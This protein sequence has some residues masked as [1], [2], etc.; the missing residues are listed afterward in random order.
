MP[1]IITFEFAV[2]LAKEADQVI[3]REATNSLPYHNLLLSSSSGMIGSSGWIETEIDWDDAANL[4]AR[5]RVRKPL[6]GLHQDSGWKS[7]ETPK[8]KCLAGLELL[9]NFINSKIKRHH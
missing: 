7:Y 8:Y 3:Y 1:A 4:G 2:E 5:W 9:T 6:D